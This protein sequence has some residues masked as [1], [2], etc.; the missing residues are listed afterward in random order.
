MSII[1]K[2][3][4]MPKCCDMCWALDEQ[5]DYPMCRIT[6]EQRGYNFNTRERKMTWCPLVEIPTPY[7][8]IKLEAE[9]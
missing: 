8:L 3:M 9:E 2:G 7:V 4:D 1:I 5:G 6:Q